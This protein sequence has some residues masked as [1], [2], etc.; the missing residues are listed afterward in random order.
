MFILLCFGN[1]IHF[2][3]AAIIQ[4]QIF[5]DEKCN[6]DVKSQFPVFEVEV[7]LSPEYGGVVASV[8]EA[9]LN[10]ETAND[11]EL[12]EKIVKGVVPTIDTILR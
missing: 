12:R 4:A 10:H 6:D 5:E 1:S 2:S 7:E 11:Q 9:V 8:S 3:I